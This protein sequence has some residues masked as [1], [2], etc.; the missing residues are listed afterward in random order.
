MFYI[1]DRIGLNGKLFKLIKFR[2]IN[3]KNGK[4]SRFTRLL[5]KTALDELPQLINILKGEMSFVGPRPLIPLEVNNTKN[6]ADAR[7]MIRPG[8]TGLAQIM[9]SKD[10]PVLE[11]LK[12]DL[13]Y[14]KN[15]ELMLD[16]ALIL[17]SFWISLSRRWEPA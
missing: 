1:Q 9:V 14:I 5:R 3:S 8:L 11:K 10:A 13:W 7:L 2:T 6:R 4:V 17:R 12:Y 15:Q 16:V